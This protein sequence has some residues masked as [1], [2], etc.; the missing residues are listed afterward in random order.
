MAGAVTTFFLVPVHYTSSAFMV[1]T[2]SVRG[3][4]V[5]QDPEKPAGLTNPLLAFNDGLKTTAA[6]LIQS[7]TTPQ[8]LKELGV[9]EGGTTTL[10]IDDGRSSTTLI[11]LGGPFVYIEADSRTAAEAYSVVIRAQQRVR[12]ELV[13][14]Q[15]ALGAPVETFI[16]LADV[17]PGSRPVAVQ[18]DR[19]Q[20]AGVT[21]VL[22]LIAGFALAYARE[23]S[24]IV[25]RHR[26][27]VLAAPVP[28]P[29]TPVQKILVVAGGTYPP[30]TSTA[31]PDEDPEDRP[32]PGPARRGDD[33]GGEEDRPD[34]GGHDVVTW[35]VRTIP[36]SRNGATPARE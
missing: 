3:G 26:A 17:V 34:P 20:A 16:M 27:A 36:A 13:R 2:T 24:R 21:F 11:D 35:E 33:P 18:S 25:R 31:G 23:R 1:L 29:D 15:K 28:F 10:V 30:Y 32:P 19:Y 9:Q 5:A 7:M 8:A 12:Q 6:I 22:A 14:R 4:E